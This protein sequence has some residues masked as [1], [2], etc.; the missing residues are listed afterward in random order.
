[1][2]KADSSRQQ[3]HDFLVITGPQ[4]KKVTRD[5]IDSEKVTNSLTWFFS[6]STAR[7]QAYTAHV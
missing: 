4:H 3:Q 7:P 5:T 1:V 6:G 2:T